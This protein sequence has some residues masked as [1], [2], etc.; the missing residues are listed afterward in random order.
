MYK[1]IAAYRNVKLGIIL[2][3][4]VRI[5]REHNVSVSSFIGSNPRRLNSL[6]LAIDSDDSARR[7][8]CVRN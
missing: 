5:D 8:D 4:F 6:E 3:A 7:A 1:D 2:E